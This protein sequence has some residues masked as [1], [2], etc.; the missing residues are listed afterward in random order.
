[1]H[2]VRCDILKAVTMSVLAFRVVMPCGHVERYQHLDGIP[3]NGANTFLR[4]VGICVQVRTA[5]RARRP[6][7]TS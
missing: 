6:S 2:L 7:L 3:K 1:M 4:N 5:I